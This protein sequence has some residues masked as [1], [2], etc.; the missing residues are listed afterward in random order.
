MRELEE[1]Q[2]SKQSNQTS[3]EDLKVTRSSLIEP[4][5]SFADQLEQVAGILIFL[6]I[7]LLLSVL[8]TGKL[9]SDYQL[10]KLAI[11][12]GY[13]QVYDKEANKVLWK[14]TEK[15]NQ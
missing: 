5:R 3:K 1:T 9:Y 13:V 11:E 4:K 2:L 10:N 6:L 15:E 8:F 12:K 7:I 14:K